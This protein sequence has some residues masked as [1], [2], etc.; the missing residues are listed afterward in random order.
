M[1]IMARRTKEAR[2][3]AWRIG[4]IAIVLLFAWSF[5]FSPNPA[6]SRAD[7]VVEPSNLSAYDATA[8]A[9]PIRGLI[10]HNLY[11]VSAEPSIARSTSEVSLPSIATS[12]SWL[13]TFGTLD[14][15]NGTATGNKVPTETTASQPGGDASQEFALQHGSIGNASLLSFGAGVAKA[16][17][18]HSNRPRGFGYGYLAGLN[19]LPAP[20]SP[21]A[22]PGSYD[23]SGDKAQEGPSPSPSASPDPQHYTPNPKQPMGIISIGSVAS[24]SETYREDT[25]VVSIAVSEL[26]GI[27]IGN[28]TAEGTCLNCITIDNLRVEARSESDG[29][30]D[31]M[32]ASYRILIH[33]ACRVA[34]TDP[35]NTTAGAYETAQCLDPNPDRIIEAVQ[36]SNPNEAEDA[37]VDSRATGVR[38]IETLDELNA[39]LTTLA[40]GLGVKDIGIKLSVGTDQDNQAS[41]T[42][43]ASSA[44]ARGLIVELNTDA[45]SNSLNQIASNSDAQMLV[46]TVDKQC[47]PIADTIGAH[48][49]VPVPRDCASAA[50]ENAQVQRVLR[51]ALG[52]VS[53][54]AQASLAPT[55]APASTSTNTSPATTP[56]APS[57][58]QSLSYVPPPASAPS[59]SQPQNV[60][61]QGLQAGPLSLHV[62]WHTIGIKPWKPKDLTKG[63]IFAGLVAGVYVL[64]RKRLFGT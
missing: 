60:T 16:T 42:P 62:D 17:A 23:P 46:Q 48:A 3:R 21:E 19:L 39:Q 24:T 2:R 59:G 49:A 11:L 57:A 8:D 30:K 31:G 33:R 26:N 6:P 34:F 44:S 18:E 9:A 64:L 25:R 41:E 4:C 22:P 1:G 53:T 35:T 5:A 40:A 7:D 50:V 10:Q 29:T 27:N 56:A 54:A 43:S 12:T 36:S 45:A 55:I 28:R 32:L 20:G 47:E 14:G 58:P 38:K 63:L 15:A 52:Q 37:L 61:L 13:L 51:I